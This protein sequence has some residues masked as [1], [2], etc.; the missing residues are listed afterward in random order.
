M[1]NRICYPRIF[2]CQAVSWILSLIRQIQANAMPMSLK[3]AE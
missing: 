3:A 2:V 1:V